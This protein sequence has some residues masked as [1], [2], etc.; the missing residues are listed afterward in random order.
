MQSPSIYGYT[1]FVGR[2]RQRCL[3]NRASM[4]IRSLTT[5][6]TKEGAW[7]EVE[8][9]YMTSTNESQGAAV[10]AASFLSRAPTDSAPE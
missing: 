8:S 2:H 6:R 10:L 3:V 1:E 9:H 5:T 7:F 4:R